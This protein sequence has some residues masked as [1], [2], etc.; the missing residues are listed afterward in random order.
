MST[1]GDVSHAGGQARLAQKD[2]CGYACDGG[3]AQLG[4]RLACTEEVTGSNPVIS[5]SEGQ[6]DVGKKVKAFFVL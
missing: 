5:T 4:E 3:V 6:K 2:A 1:S